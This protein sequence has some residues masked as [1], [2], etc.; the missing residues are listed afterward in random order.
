MFS[1]LMQKEVLS[2]IFNEKD[3][4]AK[5]GFLFIAVDNVLLPK[6]SS[7]IENSFMM[8]PLACIFIGTLSF[9]VVYCLLMF[10]L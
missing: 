9:I 8:F 5:N 4:E 10:F 2:A 7:L 6:V 3:I 1:Y